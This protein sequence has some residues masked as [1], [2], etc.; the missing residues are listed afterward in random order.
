MTNKE[1]YAKEILDI[2][3]AGNRIAI[4][5]HNNYLCACEGFD[6]NDC[7]FYYYDPNNDD[8]TNDCDAKITKWAD[9]EYKEKRN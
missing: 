5:K 1:K 4:N 9:S 6:C 7:A 3:C 8:Y 2:A